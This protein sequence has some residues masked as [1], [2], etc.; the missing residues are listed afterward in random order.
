MFDKSPSLFPIKERYAFLSH[1]G[2]AAMYGPA[3]CKE[4]RYVE[5]PKVETKS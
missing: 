4:A 5:Q 2:I 1:C 3:Q